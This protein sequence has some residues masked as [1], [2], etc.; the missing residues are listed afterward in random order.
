MIFAA[1]N[2]ETDLM[3]ATVLKTGMIE[4]GLRMVQ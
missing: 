3:K 4:L 1:V 2:G